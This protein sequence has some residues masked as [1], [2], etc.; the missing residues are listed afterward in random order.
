MTTRTAIRCLAVAALLVCMA[1]A[2]GPAYAKQAVVGDE[3][4]HASAAVYP[5]LEDL[6]SEDPSLRTGAAMALREL[7]SVAWPAIPALIEALSDPWVGVRKGAAGALGGIGPAS[8]VAVPALTL[9]L[10][11]SHRFV[12]SW[13]AMALYEIGPAA[14]PATAQLI[15]MLESDSQNL[16]G[17]SWCA[18]AL[19]RIEADPELAV[20]ALMW[21]LADDASEEVRSVAV[22]SLEQYG[23][24]A[25]RRGATLSLVDALSDRHWKVRGNAA[26]ALPEMGDDLGLAVSRLAGALRDD[27]AYVRGCAARALGE[28][29]PAA[30]DVAHELAPLLEDEDD[31]VRS[32]A[33]Q[34]LK[35]LRALDD[36]PADSETQYPAWQSFRPE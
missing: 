6:K 26:C 32:Q 28:I 17:R 27:A 31:H 35:R 20:P 1:L 24:E 23:V 19:A 33:E 16:R 22:L 18:S 34:A 13:A 8:E 14:E 11:D 12:R 15:Q 25:A 30:L 3:P 21:A 29:G 5:L 36:P 7:G 10:T 9:T 2:S 4:P